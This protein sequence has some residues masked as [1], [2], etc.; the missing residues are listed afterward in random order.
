[1]V[2]VLMRCWPFFT[3]Q[4]KTH[5]LSYV[6]AAEKLFWWSEHNMTVYDGGYFNDAGHP[7]RGITIFTINNLVNS[8]KY[9]GS[10]LSQKT[11]QAMKQR[12]IEGT[13]FVDSFLKTVTTNTNYFFAAAT[14]FVGVGQ[15]LKENAWIKRGQELMDQYRHLI[16]TNGMIIGEGTAKNFTLSERSG[17]GA[18]AIDIG[19]NV[20]ENIGSL[21]EYYHLTGDKSLLPVIK[22]ALDAT[23]NFLQVDG[24]FDN[25]FGLRN[26]KW[27]YWGSRTSDGCQLAYSY[28]KESRYQQAALLNLTQLK[29][30]THAGLLTGGPMYTENDEPTCIHHTFCHAKALVLALL[31]GQGQTQSNIPKAL[32]DH[33]FVFNHNLQMTAR[34][35]SWYLSISVSDY[36]YVPQSTPTGGTP[37]LLTERHFGPIFAATMTDFRLTEPSNMQYPQRGIVDCGSVRVIS[38]GVSSLDCL[39]ARLHVTNSEHKVVT[40]G[41]LANGVEYCIQ[42]QM[43]NNFKM[44]VTTTADAETVLPLITGKHADICFNNAKTE[45]TIVRHNAKLRVIAQG[46]CFKRLLASDGKKTFFNP[47]GGF[48]YSPISITVRKKQPILLTFL[49]D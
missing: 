3:L 8:L 24:G 40:S 33:T 6:H 32:P 48:I 14:M 16:L 30:C 39:N 4:K 17:R 37:T 25:S 12:I 46:G 20:E 23:L 31:E 10:L 7:W 2:V 18:A 19:Y 28:F 21:V 11:R 38:Q 29:S 44:T 43:N 36:V 42:Y 13:Q 15:L 22:N 34:T 9:F 5:D 45:L 1:M 27:T 35:N 47:V 41:T 26:A 49:V